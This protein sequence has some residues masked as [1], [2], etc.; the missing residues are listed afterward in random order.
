MQD[1][2]LNEKDSL[3][4]INQMILNTQRRLEQ[5]TGRVFLI[6]GYITVLTTVAVWLAIRLTAN[7]YWNYL[8]F[9]I[10]VFG[11]ATTVLFKKKTSGAKSFVDKVVKYIWL[12]QGGAGFL[13]SALSIFQVMW[14]F[15]ILFVIILLMSM[16]SIL[17]GL[18]IEFKA[19]VIG[20]IIAMAIAAV[21][22]LTNIYD[23][24][25]LTF[26]LAFLAMDIIPGH[27]L[28]YRIRK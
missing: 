4:L 10:P 23:V 2:P 3:A 27:I 24:K 14:S 21:H 16:G 18:V 5:G 8:W 20:G 1:R 19:L 22:Y 9:C 17:T 13:L 28:N 25:L 12:V 7:S 15:P 11:L 6:W 26:A